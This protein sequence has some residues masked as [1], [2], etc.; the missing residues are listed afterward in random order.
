MLDARPMPRLRLAARTALA[1]ALGAALGVAC[2]PAPP[3]PGP[4]LPPAGSPRDDGTGLL[5]RLSMEPAAGSP[6]ADEPPAAPRDDQVGDRD[7]GPRYAGYEFVPSEPYQVTPPPYQSG[8]TAEEVARGG[9]IA[10]VVSWRRPPPAAATLPAPSC[11]ARVANDSL[12]VDEGGR[13]ANAVVWLADI[14]RGRPLLSLAA[15]TMYQRRLQIGGLLERRGCRFA[16]HVQIVAPIGGVLELV[17]G[18]PGRA[19]IVGERPGAGEA[20]AVELAGRGA[21]AT[22]LLDRHGPV[23]VRAGDGGDAWVVVAGHPY[24]AVTDERGRFELPDVP[25]GRYELVVWHEPV[26]QDD[27]APSEPVVVRRA[28]TVRADRRTAVDVALR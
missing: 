13:V 14:R 26:T 6:R 2:Q 3:R 18:D 25:P 17:H 19:R 1:A 21:R 23:R 22:V 11:D 4:P 27:G 28:V 8:Y 12:L 24:Y 9:S 15:A 7:G 16:P 10:G 20:F 5:A